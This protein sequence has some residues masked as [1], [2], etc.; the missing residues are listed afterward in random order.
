MV[1]MVG[2]PLSPALPDSVSSW[3]GQGL[4]SWMVTMTG[5]GKLEWGFSLCVVLPGT[6]VVCARTPV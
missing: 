3:L 2:L 5:Y 6:Q 1:G 4:T